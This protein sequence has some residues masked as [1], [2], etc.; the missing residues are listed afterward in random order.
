[1]GALKNKKKP[2]IKVNRKRDGWDWNEKSP[3]IKFNGNKK[4]ISTAPYV[5]YNTS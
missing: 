5:I 1:M 2:P 4:R 3:R